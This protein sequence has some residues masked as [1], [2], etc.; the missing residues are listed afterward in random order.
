MVG[1][2]LGLPG[3]LAD[4][5]ATLE[6]EPNRED[7]IVLRSSYKGGLSLRMSGFSSVGDWINSHPGVMEGPF[8]CNGG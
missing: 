8:D 6:Y 4:T 2:D 3:D 7:F 5:A 1:D